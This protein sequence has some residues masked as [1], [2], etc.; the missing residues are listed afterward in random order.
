MTTVA[1]RRAASLKGWRTRERMRAA[2]AADPEPP[3]TETK[4]D[5]DE[6]KQWAA[7]K[8][9]ALPNPWLEISE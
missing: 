7:W 2:R 9:H 8:R 1:K 3:T 6:S 5:P 4:S